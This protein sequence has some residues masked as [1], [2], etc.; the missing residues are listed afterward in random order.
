[1]RVAKL[2]FAL[3]VLVGSG[4]RS[5]TELRVDQ[6]IVCQGKRVVVGVWFQGRS[7]ILSGSDS[8]A[9]PLADAAGA[10][11]L[12][13]VDVVASAA[14]AI[15]APFEP[16][17]DITWGPVGALAG[18]CLPG[19]TLV[20]HIY[21]PLCVLRPA[22]RVELEEDAFR[23]LL[24][25]LRAGDGLRAYERSVRAELRACRGE[26]LVDVVLVEE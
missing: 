19:F 23:A 6:D 14:V 21:P 7:N 5:L 18:I 3:V 13:P 11:L 2:L 12:Y 9:S 17:R 15:Q 22:P 26:Q 20:P 24:A 1:M 4:C 10:I 8:I 25:G 16:R